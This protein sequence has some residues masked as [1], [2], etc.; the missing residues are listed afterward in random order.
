MTARRPQHATLIPVMADLYRRLLPTLESQLQTFSTQTCA[1]L[2]TSNVEFACD[3][4]SCTADEIA[5]AV[6]RAEASHTDVLIIAHVAYCASGVIAPALMQTTLPVLLWPAQPMFEIVGS[7]Y[8]DEAVCLNHGVHGT[9]DLANVLRR[10]RHPHGIIHG[11]ASQSDFRRDLNQWIAAAHTLQTM[12][13]SRPLM[14]GD[15]FA[16]MLD[17]QIDD[18]PFIRHFGV[19][20]TSIANDDLARAAA[21]ISSAD[22]AT[23]LARIR[24]SFTISNDVPAEML[25]RSARWERALA[26]IIAR[27]SSRAVGIN[28]LSLCN[29]PAIGDGLHL[30]ACMQMAEG[31]GYGGEGDWITAMLVAG[32][33]SA[34]HRT[35]F[36]EIFSVGYGDG[37]LVVRHWGEGNPRLA[38]ETPIIRPSA[39]TDATSCTFAVVDFEFTPG[40]ATL[41]NLNAT[42]DGAGQ[43]I[44]ITGTIDD[45]H[46]N[47]V[48]GPRCIF[49]PNVADIRSALTAY[50]VAGGSHHLT[51]MSGHHAALIEKMSRFT[52]WSFTEIGHE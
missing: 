28:F 37:R 2:T 34:T 14:I 19:K 46:L 1:D 50:D 6:A 26:A 20:A 48:G 31:I 3:R 23:S 51:L 41:V 11:H 30:A 40:P 43:L 5:A 18:A 13:A 32:L 15:H 45:E 7:Q 8:N 35:S 29:D 38:R 21:S 27:E 9:Q 22:L 17:L 12:R 4:V 25:E 36:S 52:G 24:A 49:K 16:D 33:Q 39:F 44:A 47:A 10:N 42:P